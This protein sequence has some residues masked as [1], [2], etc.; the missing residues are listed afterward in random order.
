MGFE[1]IEAGKLKAIDSDG[2]FKLLASISFNGSYA[3]CRGAYVVTEQV[4]NFIKNSP[5]VDTVKVHGQWFKREIVVNG[6]VTFSENEIVCSHCQDIWRTSTK[7]KYC[8]S[9]GAKMDGDRK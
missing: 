8:P 5:T 3:F 7:M 2:L 4:L 1:E 9:C 6:K